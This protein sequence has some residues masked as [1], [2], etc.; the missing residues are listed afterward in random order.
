MEFSNLQANITPDGRE[1][2]GAYRFGEFAGTAARLLDNPLVRGAITYGLSKNMGDK[3]PLNEAL[4]ATVGTQ[5]NKMKDQMYRQALAE[6][7]ID[8]SGIRGWLG[9]DTFK[10][11]LEDQQVKDN[12][13]YRKLYYD[14]QQQNQ[15][16]MMEFRKWQAEKEA[17]QNKIDNYYKGQQIAQGWEKIKNDANKTGSK[18][19]AKRKQSQSTLNMIG[20][21]LNVVDQNP[22]AYGFWKGMA[23]NDI[24]NRADAQGVQARAV[25]DSVTAEYRKYLTGA[26]MSDKERK[27][28]EKFLPNPRDN[29][30]IIRRKLQG[31]QTVIQA[32]EGLF[33]DV[34]A[35]AKPSLNINN[36][37]LEAE[38]KR[39]GLK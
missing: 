27:D 6:R 15:K 4:A 33:D 31:M 7:N 5:Q 22:E 32:R 9:D 39:R 13:A 16:D 23:P 25:I 2:G 38:M 35:D 8:T 28:Y 24:T 1:K 21:A 17:E 34:V 11:L 36:N 19:E 29:A 26:Q 20:T 18:E 37:A 12:A 14:M 3:N 30:D 10:Y